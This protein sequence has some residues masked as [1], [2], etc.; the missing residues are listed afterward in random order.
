MKFLHKKK[1]FFALLLLL[2]VKSLYAQQTS[3]ILLSKLSLEEKERIVIGSEMEIPWSEGG[4]TGVGEVGGNVPGAA[5]KSLANERLNLPVVIFADGPAGVRI[6]PH[7]ASVPD[8]TFYATAFPVASL[9]AST[10]NTE[11]MRQVGKAFA[12]EAKEYGVDI[13]LAPALNIHRNPLGGRNFEYYSE[14]PLLSGKMASAFTNGVQSLGIGVSVKHYA[15]NNQ[16]TNRSRINAIVDERALREIYLKGFEITVKESKPWTVMSA[17]NK[18]NG[19]YASESYDLLTTI[20]REEWGFKGFVMTDWFAGENVPQQLKAGNDLLMPGTP[21]HKNMI[22]NAVKKGLLTEKELDRN[23]KSI[24]DIYQKTP[25]F[26]GYK[27]SGTPDLKASQKIAKETATEG[28]V[29]LKNDENT[30]PLTIN[31]SQKLALFG[32]A[33]YETIAV[34]TGSGNVNMAYSTS[35]LEG[36]EKKNLFIDN[37]VKEGYVEYIEKTKAALPPKAWSFGPDKILPEKKWTSEELDVIAQKTS[38]GIFTVN[39]TSGEFYDRQQGYD[40]YLSKE[41]QTLLKKISE[42]YHK[43]HKKMVV[44]LNIGGVIE[45]NSWKKDAD[46]ILLM[47]QGGQEGGNAVAD[48]LVGERN[49]SGKL[50]MTF[51]IQYMDHYSSINFPGKEL[52]DNPYPSGT[53]GVKS[54]VIYEEGIYVGYRYFNT[55]NVPVSYPFGFGLSYTDFEISKGDFKTTKDGKLELSCWVKNIGNKAGKEVVQFYISSPEV[56]LEKPTKELRAFV[57]TKQ[58]KPGEKQEVKVILNATDY[59]SF[60]PKRSAWILESGIYNI[61]VGNSIDHIFFKET[62]KRN[63]LLEVLKTTKSLVPKR[64]ISVLT[65]KSK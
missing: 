28:M 36:L 42:A 13:L 17:Y 12:H 15:V 23:V 35:L 49:P 26:L 7:R 50:P 39:R 63:E 25:S 52:V 29:L 10:F 32:V 44:V 60:S 43:H 9:L 34:G 56:E 2:F 24:L 47:W 51:P 58:L 16:E 6:N 8:K 61:E 48:I 65:K 38:M 21:N 53:V 55:F 22:V 31:K 11:L 1:Q 5:G 54:E 30:L 46:A 14:D 57:K 19:V 20:L 59:A 27:P 64:E 62:F 41:E 3:E 33:S 37:S 40:F 4:D 18:V 45:T